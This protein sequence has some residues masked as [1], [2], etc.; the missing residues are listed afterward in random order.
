MGDLRFKRGHLTRRSAQQ[1]VIAA[2]IGQGRV[3]E[4][5]TGCHASGLGFGLES[6]DHVEDM[7]RTDQAGFQHQLDGD[8]DRIQTRSRD[9]SQ[10]LRHDPVAAG[11]SQQGLSQSGQGFW[12]RGKRCPIAQGSRLALNEGEIMLPVIL[13]MIPIGQY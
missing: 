8:Q 11:S 2:G 10:Y 6:S 7:V 12:H 3:I 4:R 9:G 5:E 13:N 1:A